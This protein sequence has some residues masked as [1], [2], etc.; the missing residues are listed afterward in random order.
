MAYAVNI[1]NFQGPLDLLL[2]LVEQR[3]LEIT[4]LSLVEVTDPFVTH[5]RAN[6][7][8]IPPEELADFLLLAA[9]LI[10]LKSKAILPGFGEEA[11]DEGPDVENQLRTYKQ[12]V[13]AARMLGEMAKQGPHSFGRDMRS[14]TLPD[15]VFVPPAGLAGET[16]AASYR[17]V[18][19]RLEPV[20]RLPQAA[21]MCAISIEEKIDELI[22]RV[23]RA[24]KTSFHHVLRESADRGEMVV[25]F[26]ALLELIKQRIVRVKQEDLFEDIEMEHA[27]T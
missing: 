19:A 18:C 17:R 10:Y 23:K 26:L 6:E 11:F 2:Q 1:A 9:R 12:F 13:L 15:G 20:L 25:S 3:A 22:A 21:I 14:V 5:V 7:G 4:T 27:A 16:L 24:V 8:K